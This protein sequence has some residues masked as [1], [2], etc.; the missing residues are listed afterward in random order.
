MMSFH[1]HVLAV[2][3]ALAS[4]YLSTLH[5]SLP[6]TIASSPSDPP[7]SLPLSVNVNLSEDC[8][9]TEDLPKTTQPTSTFQNMAIQSQFPSPPYF[10]GNY[11]NQVWPLPAGHYFD[12]HHPYNG[13]PLETY[14]HHPFIPTHFE[15][16]PSAHAFAPPLPPLLPTPPHLPTPPPPP[17]STLL[18]LPSPPPSTAPL[19]FN[20]LAS[21]T[22]SYAIRREEEIISSEMRVSHEKVEVKGLDGP[23]KLSVSL[24]ADSYEKSDNRSHNEERQRRHNDESRS[25]R[26]SRR[27]HRGRDRD[28]SMDIEKDRNIDRDIERDREDRRRR[29]HRERRGDDERPRSRER[30]RRSSRRNEEDRGDRHSS[31]RS[32]EDRVSRHSRGREDIERR[33]RRREGEWD[34]FVAERRKAGELNESREAF[35]AHREMQKEEKRKRRSIFEQESHSSRSVPTIGVDNSSL[36]VPK[37]SM[38]K[39][40]TSDSLFTETT[41]DESLFLPPGLPSNLPLIYTYEQTPITSF[42]DLDEQLYMIAIISIPN[43]FTLTDPDSFVEKVKRY[44][45]S[46]SSCFLNVELREAKD[47]NNTEPLNRRNKLKSEFIK[48]P[49]SVEMTFKKFQEAVYQHCESI[50]NED[51]NYRWTISQVC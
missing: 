33:D 11:P 18:P 44:Q 23:K 4:R 45:T 3:D 2:N 48:I 39:E 27:E 7:L 43:C 42:K 6:D 30:E 38:K 32:R 8:P 9:M 31:M 29:R 19:N 16:Y 5:S 24:S 13:Y 35:K 12:G 47:L 22:E 17:Q 1:S 14:Q 28:R 41:Y 25:H 46:S 36:Y 49:Y 15:H 21:M 26:D 10:S 20:P 34:A 51:R 37:Y 50:S 40:S